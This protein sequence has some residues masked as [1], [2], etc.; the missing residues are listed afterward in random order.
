MISKEGTG[1]KAKRKIYLSPMI[2]PIRFSSASR[3]GNEVLLKAAHGVGEEARAVQQVADHDGLEDVELEVA[4]GAGE[5]GGG[6][7]AKDLGA[8]HGQ[9]LALGRVDFAGHDGGAR[10][11]FGQLEFA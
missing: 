7:V 2:S 4:L 11:V 8:H 9:G 3:P 6:L 5:G 1:G 10:L